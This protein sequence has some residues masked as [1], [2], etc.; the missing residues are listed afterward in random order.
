M[1]RRLHAQ[2]TAVRLNRHQFEIYQKL[3]RDRFIH[4]ARVAEILGVQE[5]MGIHFVIAMKVP[6]YTFGTGSHAKRTFLFS[7]DLVKAV[8][9][10]ERL[11]TLQLKRE[12]VHGAFGRIYKQQ[13]RGSSAG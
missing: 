13:K 3:R 8:E 11:P 12:L 5:M 7:S 1:R 9:A 6:V 10:A 2:Y 4:I